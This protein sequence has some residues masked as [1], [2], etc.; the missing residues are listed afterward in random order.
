MSEADQLSITTHPNAFL[1][2]VAQ[3]SAGHEIKVTCCLLHAKHAYLVATYLEN[4]VIR[5]LTAHLG[6]LNGT[7]EQTRII[8]ARGRHILDQLTATAKA[9]HHQ[10]QEGT[11]THLRSLFDVTKSPRSSFG[12][13]A[14]E[15]SPDPRGPRGP[16]WS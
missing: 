7:K 1:H 11:S 2:E 14:T 9:S 16:Q 6:N 13:T 3:L 5:Q 4:R 15:I 10:L 8:Q 12:D